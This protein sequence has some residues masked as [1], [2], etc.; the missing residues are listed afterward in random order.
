MF[1]ANEAVMITLWSNT[2]NIT[3][4]H[5]T[6]TTSSSSSISSSS[7]SNNNTINNQTS[8]LVTYCVANGGDV[9]KQFSMNQVKFDFELNLIELLVTGYMKSENVKGCFF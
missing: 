5:S 1:Y 8:T 6:A 2:P 9:L 3:C 7:S 4:S